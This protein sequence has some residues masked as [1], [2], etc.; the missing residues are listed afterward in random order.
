MVDAAVL[1][2]HAAQVDM[3]QKQV[4]ATAVVEGRLEFGLYQVFEQLEPVSPC[5]FQAI[6]EAGHHFLAAAEC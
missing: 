6:G 3:R 1:V 5:Y 4:Q 2:I